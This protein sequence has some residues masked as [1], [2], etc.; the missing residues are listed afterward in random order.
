LRRQRGLNAVAQGAKNGE[1]NAAT[2]GI[3]GRKSFINLWKSKKIVDQKKGCPRAVAS[4]VESTMKKRRS[5][6]WV[7]A[8]ADRLAKEVL[9]SAAGKGGDWGTNVLKT[10]AGGIGERYVVTG[11]GKR[12]LFHNAKEKGG[13][14]VDLR[15]GKETGRFDLV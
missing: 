10:R 12:R 1:G 14:N 8:E 11:E 15:W 2:L 3:W 5:K 7:G 9:E 4:I 6:H 13:T